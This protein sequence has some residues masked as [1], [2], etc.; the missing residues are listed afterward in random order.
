MRRTSFYLDD[1]LAERLARLARQEGKSQAEI[2]HFYNQR[3]PVALA[4]G[5]QL[6]SGSSSP[7]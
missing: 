2:L 5:V 4:G 7:G 1:E 3:W 6:R